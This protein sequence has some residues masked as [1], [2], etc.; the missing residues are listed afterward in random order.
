ML[1]TTAPKPAA[2]QF[3]RQS[4]Y[5]PIKGNS[6]ELV[7]IQTIQVIP[8]ESRFKVHVILLNKNKTN[9]KKAE[10]QITCCLQFGAIAKFD[11]AQGFQ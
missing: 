11:Q 6:V 8:V 5:S 10:E 7:V 9:Q 4:Q 2:C 1:I 3:F